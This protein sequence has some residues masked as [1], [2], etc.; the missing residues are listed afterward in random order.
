[1]DVRLVSPKEIQRYDTPLLAVAVRDEGGKP[2]PQLPPG[3]S[4][5]LKSG[6]EDIRSRVGHVVVLSTGLKKGPERVA[7]I[8]VGQ[9]SGWDAEAVRRFAGRAVRAAEPRELT[10]VSVYLPPGALDTALAVEAA[11]E[12]LML[13]AWRFTELKTSKEE[14]GAP[15]THVTAGAIL[16]DAK[17]RKAADEGLRFGRAVATGQN[18]ARTLQSRPGNV[19]TPEHLGE[20]ARAMAKEVGL[21][22]EVFDK[23]RIEKERMHA[24]LAVNQGSDIEPR[25]IVL[26]HRGGKPKQPFLALVGK[27]LTFDAGGISIKP[28]Q[29]MEEMKYDMSG[30]AAVFGAMR[31]IAE[32]GLPLNV[33]G[34]VPSTENLLSGKAVKPGDI[35]QSRGGKTIEVINTD[36]EGRLILADALD[37]AKSLKVA[38]IVDMATLTGSVVIALGA[39][40]IAVLGTD[41]TL[42]QQLRDAGQRAGERCW[43][44]PLWAEYR[45]QLKSEVA[46]MMNVGGRP[47]GT[48]TAAWFLREF[49]GD[50]PWAHLDIAGTAYGTEPLPYQRKGGYG[51]PVRLLVEWLRARVA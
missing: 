31:A 50:V 4:S 12:G 6:R 47:A 16:I 38:S 34:L 5:V 39:H 22:I 17:A 13:A 18:F 46:D 36:A 19:A 30:G 32:I 25:F 42:I 20:E 45:K 21:E 10:S 41:E 3:L 37:Y 29:G 40:A 7:F 2:A 24:L 9:A 28:A 51:I 8:G 44:L 14:D 15:V 35:I 48:I 1:V 11:T 49:V 27:G 23:K 26:R 43:P 33:I